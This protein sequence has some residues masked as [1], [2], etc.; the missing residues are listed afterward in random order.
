MASIRLSPKS[1]IAALLIVAPIAVAYFLSAE[2]VTFTVDRKDYGRKTT[3]R[4][5]RTLFLVF[6]EQ[7][8]F[9]VGTSWLFLKFDSAER[10]HALQE[11]QTY[12]AV[13]AG[14]R[15]PVI[16]EYRNIIE[17]LDEG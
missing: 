3:E 9:E 7:E 16:S 5:Y 17:V 12:R 15:I 13:V 2:Q 14:W 6:T 11:G 10:Y 8:V 4:S 1:S